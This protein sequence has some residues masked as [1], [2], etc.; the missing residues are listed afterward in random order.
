MTS[1]RLMRTGQALWKLA[2]RS[3]LVQTILAPEE[4]DLVRTR[5]AMVAAALGRVRPPAV[6]VKPP[7]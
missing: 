1:P 2:D 4:G 7:S 5:D 6:A 3:F